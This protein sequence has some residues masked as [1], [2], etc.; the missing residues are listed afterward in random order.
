MSKKN[1]KN[2]NSAMKNIVPGNPK[3]TKQFMRD[4]RKSL[5]QR[6]LTP[7]ISVIRRVLKRRFSA[8]TKRN[9]FVD[10]RAWLISIQNPD[11]IRQDWPL[12]THIVNQCISTT[13]EYATSFFKST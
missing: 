2:K 6:K 10:R 1:V 5:G 7:L 12:I 11:N 3:K 4:A 8:S 13:V 9:E